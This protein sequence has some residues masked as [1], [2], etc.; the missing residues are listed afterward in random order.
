MQ[1]QLGQQV[2]LK[3]VFHSLLLIRKYHCANPKTVNIRI[4]S[5]MLL[6]CEQKA[7]QMQDER[8]ASR[9]GNQKCGLRFLISYLIG[10]RTIEMSKSNQSVHGFWIRTV[11]KV[12]SEQY[13][14]TSFPIL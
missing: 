2:I 1:T 8:K 3:Q 5:E 13:R 7:N 4:I 6:W 12:L 11:I 10:H 9:N 14:V